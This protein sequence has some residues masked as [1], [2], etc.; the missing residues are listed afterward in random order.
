[1]TRWKHRGAATAAAIAVVLM[2]GTVGQALGGSAA[3]ATVVRAAL[4]P[5]SIKHVIVI[6]LENESFS[7][8][9]GAT[10]PATYLNQTLVPKG[11]LIHHYYATGH[12]SLDN[13]IA[14]IS[15]QAPNPLTNSDV[16]TGRR[17]PG[18]SYVNV[19]PGN[20]DPEQARVPGPG[21]RAG[22]RLAAPLPPPLGR[23]RSATSS[24]PPPPDPVTHEAS[25]REY[26]E[27]MGND[28]T[29]DGGTADPLGGHRL[30]APGR[31][32]HRQHRGAE[33]TDPVRQPAQPVRLLPLRD[34]QHAP[35]VTPTWCPL[36]TVRWARPA[37]SGTPLA[38]TFAGHLAN[39]LSNRARRRRAFMFITPN[40]CN[41]GHDGTCAGTNTEGGK[42]GGL[43]GADLWLKHWMPLILGSPGVQGRPDARG[44]DLRRGRPLP[45]RPPAATS[46]P[47]PNW[48]Y[49]GFSP[50]LGITADHRRA[51]DPGGGEIGALL[52]NARYIQPG[53]VDTTGSYNHYSALRSY[54]D[55][56]GITSGGADGQGHLGFAAASGLAPFGQDVFSA[57][58]APSVT[59]QPTDQTASPGQLST[60]SAAASGTPTP[61][62]QWQISTD[63]GTTWS[64]IVG[65]STATSTTLSGVIFGTFENGWKVRAVFT[66][67]SGSATTNPA[68]LTV[69]G[70]VA[71]SVTAQPN[72]QT[73]SPGQVST[74]SAAASGTPTPT[75][76]W[77]ISTDGGT[78][79]SNIAG[80]S[81][82]TSTTLRGVIF[83]TFENGWKVRAVFTNGSGSAT[84]NPA[85]LTVQ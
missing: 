66:N 22:L 61:T 83:G 78:T 42:T 30:C 58:V 74:F 7:T 41:D 49:P 28:P 82:A 71:P 70:P 23:R 54:E 4:P 52:L 62:V 39:D 37:R 57:P 47:G 29:R 17:Q 65:N 81:T 77:Q 13:Y 8:T 3:G 25:W 76:Q 56:L 80:N 19:S 6:D 14:Q 64:N 85:T 43:V 35:N 20:L 46:S 9:F 51:P 18:R 60:F 5:G 59:T 79:W 69:A 33:A 48:A 16:P 32:W 26:A 67:G 34:R 45:T 21:R 63:G 50:L 12:V 2:V 68:T 44:P 15:G 1:M 84:T 55:L 38:D 36:G 75:V 40:L 11:E 73:D 10:S 31:G 72:D 53:T 24:T 27:D